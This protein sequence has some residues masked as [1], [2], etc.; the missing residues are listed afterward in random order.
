[1]SKMFLKFKN[2]ISCTIP[3]EQEVID[4]IDNKNVD[5]NVGLNSAEKKVIEILIYNSNVYQNKGKIGSNKS[6]EII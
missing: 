2:Y 5:L 1:M 4:Q 6:R 3:F